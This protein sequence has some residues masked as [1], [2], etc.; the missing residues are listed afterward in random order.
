MSSKSI[1]V[2]VVLSV[3]VLVLSVIFY[4]KHSEEVKYETEGAELV[5]RIEKYRRQ[6]SRLP[7]SVSELGLVEESDEGPYY[8]KKDSVNYVVYFNIGFD[9]TKIYFS[10]TGEWEYVH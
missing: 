3:L 7:H 10:Q 2:L 6:W 5:R 9:D 8:E 1:G 4:S